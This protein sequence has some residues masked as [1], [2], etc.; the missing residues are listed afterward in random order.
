[1]G[2]VVELELLQDPFAGLD[3]LRSGDAVEEVGDESEIEGGRRFEVFI[4]KLFGL[5]V[6]DAIVL[7]AVVNKHRN[8]VLIKVCL[9][10][11]LKEK[12]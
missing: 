5:L 3:E 8:R 7:S 2:Y 10:L 6:V 11:F 12:V 9:P 1:M 4:V